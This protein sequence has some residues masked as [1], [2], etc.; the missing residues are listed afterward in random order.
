MARSSEYTATVLRIRSLHGISLRDYIFQR[1]NR[2]GF[3]VSQLAR[4]LGLNR[5][6]TYEYARRVGI[7]LHNR[8]VALDLW[9]TAQDP[10][11]LN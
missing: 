10:D 11:P 9:A 5:P 7:D 3:N 2:D 8:T 4:D 6:R 1:V